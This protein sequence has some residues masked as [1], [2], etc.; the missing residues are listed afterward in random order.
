MDFVHGLTTICMSGRYVNVKG[1]Q[2]ELQIYKRAMC[3]LVDGKALRGRGP[4]EMQ[5][6]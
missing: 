2:L 1:T 6:E 5:A 4:T 3:K